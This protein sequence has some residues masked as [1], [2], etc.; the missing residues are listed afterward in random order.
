MGVGHSLN[1]GQMLRILLFVAFSMSL[2]F[3]LQFVHF[4]V[5]FD[6]E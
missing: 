5:R 2:L 3:L 6:A 1:T 4:S